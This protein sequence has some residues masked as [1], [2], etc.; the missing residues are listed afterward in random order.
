MAARLGCGDAGATPLILIPGNRL[1]LLVELGLRGVGAV[2]GVQIRAT[3]S[4]DCVHLLV[5]TCRH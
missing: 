4:R 1:E 2:K 5:S 3:P